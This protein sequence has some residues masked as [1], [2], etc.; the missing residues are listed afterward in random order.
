ME[1]GRHLFNSFLVWPSSIK[2]NIV[3]ELSYFTFSR[4]GRI[5][6]FCPFVSVNT[7]CHKRDLSAHKQPSLCFENEN[8]LIQER[9]VEVVLSEGRMCWTDARIELIDSRGGLFVCERHG[10]KWQG[11]PKAKGV[12]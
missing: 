2:A 6:A 7:E 3:A 12:R 10:D 4:Y 9:K 11:L 8:N 1:L 5:P